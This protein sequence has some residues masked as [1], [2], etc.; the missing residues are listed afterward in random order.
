MLLTDMPERIALDKICDPGSNR[1]TRSTSFMEAFTS[2]ALLSAQFTRSVVQLIKTRM[3][4]IADE[5]RVA[6]VSKG[7]HRLK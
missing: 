2:C 4:K 7:F 3:D 6:A 5:W 1:W